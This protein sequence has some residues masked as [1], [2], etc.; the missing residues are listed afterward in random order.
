[1]ASLRNFSIVSA[2][3]FVVPV[4]ALAVGCT[5]EN[6]DPPDLGPQYTY[7]AETDFC[8]AIAAAECTD[9]AVNTCYGTDTVVAA[10]RASCITARSVRSVCN[11][12]GNTYHPEN[13]DPCV[14]KRTAI[15]TDASLT[16]TE[17]EEDYEACL[18]VFSLGKPREAECSTDLECDTASKLR[19]VIK[20]G[21]LKGQCFEPIEA[22]G[23]DKCTDPA[24]ICQADDFC[25]STNCL[26]R[27]V[28]GET[29]CTAATCLPT[30]FLPCEEGLT[31][32]GT[33]PTCQPKLANGAACASDDECA[34]FCILTAAGTSGACAGNRILSFG[35][36]TCEEF[37][38]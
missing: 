7:P 22:E 26:S 33:T 27:A 9:K 37:R 6:D 25:D 16:K 35:S 28:E 17:I 2:L 18:A 10:D 21:A 20:S 36:Q 30:E 13:A 32:D 31:C 8:A 24:T 23:G 29:C 4:G 38:P 11:P 5:V 34:G 1:M 12:S 19:C 3:L 14:A 15:Y